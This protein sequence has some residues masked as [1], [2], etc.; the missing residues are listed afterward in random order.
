[1]RCVVA[2]ARW[3]T[4]R[5]RRIA[6]ADVQ[7]LNLWPT[8]RSRWEQGREH[9]ARSRY[10]GYHAGPHGYGW[11]R[12][13][14][15][16][17]AVTGL[18]IHEPVAIILN[19]VKDHDQAFPPD[20]VVYAAIQQGVKTY[21]TIVEERGL[22]LTHAADDLA[23][24]TIEQ[25]TLLEALIWAWVRTQL[26]QLLQDW[27]I[28]L[29]ESEELSVLG[30]TCGLGDQVGTAEQHDRRECAGIMWMTR[31]DVICKSKAA[32]YRYSYWELKS[33]G[34]AGMNWEQQWKHRVQLKAG[35]LGAEQR[36]EITIEEVY[37]VALVKGRN[38]AAEWDPIERKASGPKISNTVLI[39]GFLQPANPP[40]Y[41]ETWAAKYNFVGDDGKAHRLA[42]SYVRTGIWHLNERY[43]Q[44]NGAL[45]PADYWTR[46]LGVDTLRESVRVVGPIY[47]QQWQLDGFLRQLLAEERRYQ[48]GCQAVY[49]A[50][51]AGA[52]WGSEA[53]E[54]L[55]DE[56]F[57]QSRGG[58]CANYF[59][60]TCEHLAIC[61]RQPGWEDPSLLGMIPRRPHHEAE[62]RQAIGR[63]LLPPAEGMEEDEDS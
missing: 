28:V 4:R 50:L 41:P 48:A 38:M 8:D 31:G 30:C 56:H 36:L 51:S 15:S 60:G 61:D 6:V 3:L 25:T 7:P 49:E 39:Y 17:P 33:T 10:Q 62:L 45:S 11:R 1:M 24:K 59:G 58:H 47:R 63:G 32:P 44:D 22:Q 18:L 52:V 20:A 34:Y 12:K 23:T 53:V 54:A 57:P 55:L 42:K 46:W 5:G 2:G 35:V 40:L 19:W 13:A 21:L 9:C 27:T 43:W 37:V 26:A 14:Q 29:V 16:I